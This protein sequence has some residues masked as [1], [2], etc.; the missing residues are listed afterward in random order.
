M[1]TVNSI[2]LNNVNTKR[3]KE[4]NF[5]PSKVAIYLHKNFRKVRPEW[6]IN[7]QEEINNNNKNNKNKQKKTNQELY[8]LNSTDLSEGFFTNSLPVTVLKI[9][10]A[11]TIHRSYGIMLFI[12]CHFFVRAI[13]FIA[14]FKPVSF[15]IL[16][17]FWI[18]ELFF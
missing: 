10:L 12:T 5:I 13:V 18:Y 6:K 2:K 17:T 9:C 14:S 15:S 7:S 1:I 4:V 8:P 11:S 3:Y 16:F